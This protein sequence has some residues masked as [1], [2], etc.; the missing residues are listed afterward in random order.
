TNPQSYILYVNGTAYATGSWQSSDI[1]FKENIVPIDNALDK[2][3]K[4]E[5]VSFN[6]KREEYKDKGFPQG[7]HFGLIAQEVEKVL[8]EVVNTSE[9]E[10]SISYTELIPVLIN[11]IKELR[12]E[13]E[14]LKSRI[15]ILEQE[16]S[17]LKNLPT[18][19]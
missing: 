4:L 7:R 14:E 17:L 8:P 6:W 15:E 11:A 12:V 18:R 16:V 2:I 19:Q 5:G 3:L 13:N 9:E 1:K 10:K